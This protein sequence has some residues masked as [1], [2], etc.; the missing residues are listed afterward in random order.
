[1]R[2]LWYKAAD[3]REIKTPASRTSQTSAHKGKQKQSKSI[4]ILITAEASNPT[5]RAAFFNV[6]LSHTL[7]SQNHNVNTSSVWIKQILSIYNFTALV[8]NK[9]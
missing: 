4:P 8:L 5:S 1:M 6:N 9:T 3:L 7:S 2:I